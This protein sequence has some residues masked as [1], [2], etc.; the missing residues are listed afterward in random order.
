M[1]TRTH[2]IV[3]VR[4][5]VAVHEWLYAESG[6][7]ETSVCT[8]VREAIGDAIEAATGKPMAPIK[9]T[10]SYS[11]APRNLSG[12]VALVL[13]IAWT[14]AIRELAEADE[15]AGSHWTGAAVE[16]FMAKATGAEVATV[17][18]KVKATPEEK[19]AK[20]RAWKKK[21][22]DKRRAGGYEPATVSKRATVA[23]VAAARHAAFVSM[24]EASSRWPTGTN[25]SM[26]GGA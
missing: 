26:W 19:A 25:A 22:D 8:I 6:R 17:G 5:T 3:H 2:Q 11:N 15:M 16:R 20:Q 13:P 14:D 10:E 9:A 24:C 23:E 7:R 21:H 4:L 12:R 18:Q 1:I